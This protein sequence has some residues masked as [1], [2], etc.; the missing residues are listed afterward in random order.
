MT[1]EELRKHA[2][3]LRGRLGLAS[4][5]W[6][7]KRAVALLRSIAEEAAREA[8]ELHEPVIRDREVAAYT[9]G[10]DAGAREEREACAQIADDPYGDS[11]NQ[12]NLIAAEIRARG[13]DHE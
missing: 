12:E 10:R 3:D 8:I 13:T 2:E 5:P 1:D 4:E 9:D 11:C 7:I 6:S